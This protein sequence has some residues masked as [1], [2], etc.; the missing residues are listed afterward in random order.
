MPEIWKKV[1]QKKLS[2]VIKSGK[3]IVYPTDTIYGIGCDATN[4]SAVRKIRQIKKRTEKPFSVIAPSKQWI[5]NNFKVKNRTY[6]QKL[7]GPFTYLLKTKKK[8]FLPREVSNSDVIGV[9]ISDNR[10]TKM[11]QK[12]GRPFITTSVNLSGQ[13]HATAVEDID[14]EIFQKVDIVIDAGRLSNPPS[15]IID[16]TGDLPK[17]IRR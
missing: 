5:Y 8:R 17:I 12:S 13:K 4:A 2:E 6:I 10:I 3:I 1:N 9:R 16:L 15:T 14:P 7:P 11:I